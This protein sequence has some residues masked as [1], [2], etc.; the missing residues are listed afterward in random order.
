MLKEDGKLAMIGIGFFMVLQGKV[1]RREVVKET[2]QKE[3]FGNFLYSTI[4][5]ERE[6]ER[7]RVVHPIV[8]FLNLLNHHCV[9]MLVR[10]HWHTPNGYMCLSLLQLGQDPIFLFFLIKSNK[11]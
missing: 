4:K 2:D 3:E 5:R 6:R 1:K 10:G 11:F 8:L 9:A 7:E